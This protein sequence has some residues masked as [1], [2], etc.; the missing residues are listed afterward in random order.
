MIITDDKVFLNL[1]KDDNS[2]FNLTFS[3]FESLLEE[4]KNVDL[5]PCEMFDIPNTK[6]YFSNDSDKHEFNCKIYKTMMG[7]D[8]WIM[9]M[10]DNTEGY[11]LYLNPATNKFE[12]SWYNVNLKEPLSEDEEEKIR[13][14]YVPIF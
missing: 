13:T 10:K 12:L 14:C 3:E 4:Y 9:L 11:A 7:S 1:F 6:A 5:K 8:K 2:Y